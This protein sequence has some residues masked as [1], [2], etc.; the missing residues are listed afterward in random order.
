MKE[1]K[2]LGRTING[3]AFFLILF[4]LALPAAILWLSFPNTIQ[5]I[6]VSSAETAEPT[7]EEDQTLRFYADKIRGVWIASVYNLNF[8]SS[9]G[10]SREELEQ[11]LD[12]IVE[13]ADRLSL[14]TLFFQVRP[15]AD[16]LYTSN[17]FPTS[18]FLSG[19]QGKAADGEFDPL[20][21]LLEKAHGAGIAVYAWVN[22]LRVTCGSATS[23]R[24]DTE[25][26]SSDNP[27]RK[28]PEWTVA[29][30]DGKL[31]FDP[32]YPSVRE[33]IATGVAELVTCYDLD[34]VVFDDYFYP[35]PARDD[36]G[37]IAVFDDADSYAAYGRGMELADWR[38]ENVN[39]LVRLSYDTVKLLDPECVFG[40]SP[41]GIWKNGDGGESGSR[42]AGLSAY[43]EI[44]CDALAWAEGGY[45][46][47]LAPQLY[48]FTDNSVA[49]YG[50]LVSWWKQAL[51]GTG[52]SLLISHGAYRYATTEK[53]EGELTKELLLA[54]EQNCD[55]SIFYGYSQICSNTSGLQDEV[56]QAFA[57]LP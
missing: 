42:T 23:P 22:P 4:T 48:W 28:H 8:P 56:V 18:Y 6:I 41:F 30:A 12:T 37:E 40:V 20:A 51:S 16:A 35:Y 57:E 13:N 49:P 2:R 7:P 26:L 34:G 55:G 45:V 14:N 38:R 46:D 11:E 1:E 10:L 33:M 5:E 52:V 29:Y 25:A 39:A 43:D 32:G 31:Y 44:Y 36:S 24:W 47:F 19:E 54:M 50:E 9:P 53:P 21:Y 27:A 17:L 15:S 3:A